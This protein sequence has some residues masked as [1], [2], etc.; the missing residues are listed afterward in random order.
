VS[1]EQHVDAVHS[2]AHALSP[3]LIVVSK[4]YLCFV[5]DRKKNDRSSKTAELVKSFVVSFSHHRW[6]GGLGHRLKNLSVRCDLNASQQC[7]PAGWFII[8]S[9]NHGERAMPSLPGEIS[10][11]GGQKAQF[12]GTRTRSSA[13]KTHTSFPLSSAYSTPSTILHY[14]TRFSGTQLS[15][16]FSVCLTILT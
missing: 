6:H 7:R 5:L 4:Q 12:T 13:T 8:L 14:S 3:F 11:I 10:F 9:V 2:R 15:F 1:H 16:P